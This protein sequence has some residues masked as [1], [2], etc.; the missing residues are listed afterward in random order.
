MTCLENKYSK[1][2]REA[3]T[4]RYILPF[5]ATALLSTNTYGFSSEFELGISVPKHCKA[6]INGQSQAVSNTVNSFNVYEL[7]N[8]PEGYKLYSKIQ[9]SDPEAEFTVVYDDENLS[10]KANSVF[11][12]AQRDNPTNKSNVMQVRTES[13]HPINITIYVQ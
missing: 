13:K 6:S 4:T 5:I 12:L 10:T 11:L 2:L 9:S 3:F 8:A 1:I 7:C